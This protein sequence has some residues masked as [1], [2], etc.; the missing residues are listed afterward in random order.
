MEAT[1]K[2]VQE[3]GA[4]IVSFSG[5]LSRGL[6]SLTAQGRSISEKVGL[7]FFDG[8]EGLFTPPKGS[9]EEK[10]AAFQSNME[11]LTIALARAAEPLARALTADDF[12]RAARRLGK[13]GDPEQIRA[14]FTVVAADIVRKLDI[15]F[16]EFLGEPS[17]LTV[18]NF[19]DALSPEELEELELLREDG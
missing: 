14:A 12:R 3:G 7:E 18:P 8:V 17:G 6:A 9:T 1:F 10:A 4:D 15:G 13:S 11:S 16:D 5:A 19:G 2:Q